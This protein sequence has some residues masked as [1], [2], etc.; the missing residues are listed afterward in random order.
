MRKLLSITIAMF[1]CAS[2][3]AQMSEIRGITKSETRKEINLFGVEDG[4]LT[5]IATTLLGE[6]GSFGFLFTPAAEGFYAVGYNDLRPSSAQY[7][8]YL[9]KGDKTELMIDGKHMEYTGKQTPEN[10]V[11]ASWNK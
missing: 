4:E 1:I 3:F 9:K 7:P 5:L 2:S 11:L 10:T 8:V 6:D